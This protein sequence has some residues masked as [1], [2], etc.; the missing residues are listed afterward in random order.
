MPVS[1]LLRRSRCCRCDADAAFSGMLPC[2]RVLCYP[3]LSQHFLVDVFDSFSDKNSSGLAQKRRSVAPVPCSALRLRSKRR[4]AGRPASA[5]GIVPTIA[6][7]DA[8]NW[9]S[10]A[11]RRMSTN[12]SEGTVLDSA[13][14]EM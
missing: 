9:R 12:P 6:L 11:M 7:L 3:T 13:L 10:A 8:S 2:T 4:S 1:A 14:P 5:G